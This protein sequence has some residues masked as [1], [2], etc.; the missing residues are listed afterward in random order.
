MVKRKTLK[1]MKSKKQ[2]HVT[3]FGGN[4]NCSNHVALFPNGPDFQQQIYGGKKKQTRK[5]R[6]TKMLK[7]KGGSFS[8]LW[9]NI[10]NPLVLNTTNTIDQPAITNYYSTN[11]PKI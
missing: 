5:K 9:T 1:K 10:F 2:K 4:G 6:K 3:F 8:D 7:K 11:P